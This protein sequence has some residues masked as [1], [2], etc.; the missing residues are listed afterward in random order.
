MTQ[1]AGAGEMEIR[2]SQEGKHIHHD[3]DGDLFLEMCIT[4]TATGR[5]GIKEILTLK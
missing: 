3:M 2:L 1:M 4:A 5:P